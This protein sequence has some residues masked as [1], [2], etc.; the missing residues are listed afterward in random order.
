MNAAKCTEQDYIQFLIAT[1]RTYS[2]TEAAK[3]SPKLNSPPAHDSFTRL[4]TRD[5]KA[6]WEEV[7]PEI[8]KNSGALVIDDSTLDKPY[9]NKMDLVYHHFVNLLW[10]DGDSYI[11]RSYAVANKPYNGADK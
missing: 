8:V 9:A 4:L 11:P 2:C 5:S 7:A 1:P 3:V 6:L 10:T